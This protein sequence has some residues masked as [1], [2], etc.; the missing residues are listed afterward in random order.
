MFLCHIK[1][2]N[3]SCVCNKKFKFTILFCL[4]CWQ[5]Q[6]GFSFVCVVVT[7]SFANVLNIL[8]LLSIY[9][10]N[11]HHLWIFSYRSIHL[12]PISFFF[13]VHFFVTFLK[14]DFLSCFLSCHVFL[15]EKVRSENNVVYPSLNV[16]MFC[17][18]F[19]LLGNTNIG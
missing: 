5:T 19:S 12:L 11:C 4:C 10:C 18:S 6:P 15:C 3:I 16:K 2:F 9:I 7:L 1:T 14:V 8:H 17:F 13:S